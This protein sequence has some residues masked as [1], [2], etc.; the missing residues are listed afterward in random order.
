MDNDNLIFCHN[1]QPVV[2]CIPGMEGGGDFDDDD[3]DEGNND[4]RRGGLFL[5]RMMTKTPMAMTPWTTTASFF[6]TTT[7]LWADAF[8]SWTGG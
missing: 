5:L 3:N 8:L 2:R 1:N 6:D 7:N 4:G